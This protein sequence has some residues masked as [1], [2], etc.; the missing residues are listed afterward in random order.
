MTEATRENRMPPKKRQTEMIQTALELAEKIG[1]GNLT[2]ENIGH[3]CGLVPSMVN[4]RFGTMT[5]M[6]RT[7]IRAAIKNETL[8]VI[9]YLIATNHPAAKNIPSDLKFRALAHLTK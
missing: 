6:R 5:E 7:I 3:A 9:A 8:P 4:A 2:R 1:F